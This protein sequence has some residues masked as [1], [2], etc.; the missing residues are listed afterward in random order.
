[1]V[2]S[3]LKLS[4]IKWCHWIHSEADRLP[5]SFTTWR[6]HHSAWHLLASESHRRKSHNMTTFCDAM[7]SAF[8][9][10]VS[11]VPLLTHPSVSSPG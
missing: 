7:T 3:S 2:Y 10:S 1:M 8:N 5:A 9:A 6:K 11:E 4:P